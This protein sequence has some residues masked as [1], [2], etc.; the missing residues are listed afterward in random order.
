MIEVART[1]AV[2]SAPTGSGSDRSAIETKAIADKFRAT[3]VTD[4]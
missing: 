4:P 1:R 3:G 2:D